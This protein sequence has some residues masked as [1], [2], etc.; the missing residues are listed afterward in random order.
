M[1]RTWDR[2]E[3]RES[4]RAGKPES[5][6]EDSFGPSQFGPLGLVESHKSLGGLRVVSDAF[7]SET[8]QRTLEPASHKELLR[9]ILVKL[10]EVQGS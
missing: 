1:T 3:R 5:T 8:V 7:F 4:R 9:L 2:S 6:S 10:L